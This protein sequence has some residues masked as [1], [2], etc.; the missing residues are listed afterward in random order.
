MLS[1]AM[2]RL[3]LCFLGNVYI[4]EG[5]EEES[6]KEEE[7]WAS[8]QGKLRI[9]TYLEYLSAT[10]YK[11]STSCDTYLLIDIVLPSTYT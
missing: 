9:P 2:Y 7:L 5:E 4:R 11:N 1:S 8:L 10:I 6:R 3:F